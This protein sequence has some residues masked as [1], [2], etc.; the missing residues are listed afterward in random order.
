M[1]TYRC[2]TRTAGFLIL[3]F[4]LSAVV[5]ADDLEKGTYSD[6]AGD[7]KRSI[8]Y[9]EKG[10]TTVSRNG[11]IVVE[12]TYKVKGDELELTDENGPMACAKEQKGKYKFKLDG[13][14]LTLTKVSDEC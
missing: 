12:G 8:K 11:E 5:K 10:K 13:K 9:D 2:V 4:G 14:K 3:L 1:M 6:T 7:V